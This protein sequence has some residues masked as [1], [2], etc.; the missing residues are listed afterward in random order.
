MKKLLCAFLALLLLS[1]S[2]TSCG[3]TVQRPDIKEGEFDVS[4]TY[5]VNGEIKTLNLVYICEYAG[6]DLTLDGTSYRSWNGHF[7]GYEDGD[8]IPVLETENGKVALCFLIYPEYFMGEP[9]YATDFFPHVLT[10][11]IY[12]EDGVEMID[13]DQ[14]HIAESYGVKIIGCEYDTPIENEFGMFK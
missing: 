11:Y 6:V 3:L 5:E 7:D 13:D 1:L 2:L 9:D 4:I 10:N 8:V 12:Y 14:E